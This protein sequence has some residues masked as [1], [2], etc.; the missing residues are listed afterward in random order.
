MFKV[1]FKIRTP[2][3]SWS[4]LG[5]YGTEAQ[6]ISAALAKKQ[7]GAILVRVTNTKGQVVYSS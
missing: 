1:Q 2:S 6:A 5:S 7:K 4:S 3:E